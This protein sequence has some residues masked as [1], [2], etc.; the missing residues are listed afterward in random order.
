MS[1]SARRVDPGF[2]GVDR[3]RA[4]AARERVP[5]DVVGIVLQLA[6]EADAD[7]I[8]TIGNR[9][10]VGADL[11]MP[12]KRLRTLL[13]AAEAAGLIR[14]ERARN[15]HEDGRI[16][17]LVDLERPRSARPER[18]RADRVP[19]PVPGPLVGPVP[20]PNGA[21]QPGETHPTENREQRTP[22]PPPVDDHAR[23]ADDPVVGEGWTVDQLVEAIALEGARRDPTVDNP[24]AVLQH[25]IKWIRDGPQMLDTIERLTRYPRTVPVELLVAAALGDRGPLRRH[26]DEHPE[27]DPDHHPADCPGGCDGTAFVSEGTRAA[28]CTRTPAVTS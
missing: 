23:A 13:E 14:W 27:H 10:E 18:G 7:G 3:R 20:G 21:E 5:G 24:K 6:V 8:Y 12:W 16:V 1:R 15:Q 9:Q 26:V 22:P 25:R 17:V 2:F 19:G 11:N 4:R 28:R